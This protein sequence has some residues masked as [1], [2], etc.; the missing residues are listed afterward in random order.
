[1]HGAKRTL[2]PKRLSVWDA[3]LAAGSLPKFQ[4]TAELAECS[5]NSPTARWTILVWIWRNDITC[6]FN[7]V[8]KGLSNGYSLSSASFVTS[9]YMFSSLSHHVQYQVSDF[10][11]NDSV[12]VQCQT[13]S[14]VSMFYQQHFIMLRHVRVFIAVSET[15]SLSHLL[16]LKEQWWRH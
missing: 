7:G 4:I 9:E 12:A 6:A 15:T 1:M 14:S 11:M 2:C 8:Q 3:S 5:A 10:A 13:C 16:L